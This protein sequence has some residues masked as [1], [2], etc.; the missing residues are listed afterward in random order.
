[1]SLC[2]SCKL[3]GAYRAAVSITDSAVLIHSTIGC[4]WGTSTFHNT[5]KLM[6]IRQCSSVIYEED[7]VYGGRRTLEKA[8]REVCDNYDSSVVFVLT[9]CVAEI[10]E[11]DIEG[12]IRDTNCNKDIKIIKSAGFKG[13]ML[14]GMED[15]MRLLADNMKPAAPK[16]NS[17]NLI[18]LFSDDFKIDADL[19]AV[20][21]LL[22]RQ[23]QINC[24]MPYDSYEKIQE[25]PGACLNVVFSGFEPVGAY[26]QERFGTP[27]IVAEYPYG[28]G[29]SKKFCKAIYDAL[30][31]KS[32]FSLDA[33]ER[34]TLERLEHAFDYVKKFYGM[35]AA[36]VGDGVRAASLKAFLESELGLN[37]EVFL[38][39]FHDTKNR[40]FDKEIELSNS[41][42][43]FGSSF[44]RGWADRYNI[45]LIRYTYPVFD[46]ISIG[47]KN[48]AGFSG[49]IN[50][51]E[52]MVNSI[53]TM[54][55]RRSGM[56]G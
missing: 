45:P 18:G 7:I 20:R 9:G 42:M 15:A 35:P 13:D 48:Y 52:D 56:Y 23:I 33:L 38:N 34:I 40:D 8:L 22:G 2:K 24:V 43:I 32:H 53:M 37:V 11:D 14:S 1:M 26:M 39:S 44:E 31:I 4:N 27:Y 12:I 36:V 46:S 51:V 30:N 29:N 6:D 41:I 10:M 3:F 49:V 47:N 25:A 17:I 21:K 5:S 50:L 28:I 55:Y 19:K 16:K 54:E